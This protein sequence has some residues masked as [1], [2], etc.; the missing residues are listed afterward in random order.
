[1][2]HAYKRDA[3]AYKS[4][5]R[6]PLPLPSLPPRAE[7]SQLSALL[8]APSLLATG[9]T[10]SNDRACRSISTYGSDRANSASNDTNSATSTSPATDAEQKSAEHK[11]AEHPRQS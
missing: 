5:T 4:R 11:S 10:S 8:V 7:R 1:L 2:A 9:M 3:R 6:S